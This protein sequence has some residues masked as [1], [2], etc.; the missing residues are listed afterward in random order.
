MLRTVNCSSGLHPGVCSS[1]CMSSF[2]WA[3]SSL[4]PGRQAGPCLL[5]G[6]GQKECLGS[7]LAL[8]LPGGS[9][10]RGEVRSHPL[11]DCKPPRYGMEYVILAKG[12][13]LGPARSFNAD[14]RKRKKKR[15]KIE[16]EES[17]QQN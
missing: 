9:D 10:K 11:A 14:R 7:A 17:I 12:P 4:V 2:P 5:G 1:L 13:A 16:R 15:N 8:S 3:S 6:R